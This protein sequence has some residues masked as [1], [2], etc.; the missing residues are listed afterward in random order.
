MTLHLPAACQQCGVLVVGRGVS[1]QKG[2]LGSPNGL[3]SQLRGR[4]PASPLRGAK[5]RVPVPL[6]QSW[7][8]I[9]GPPPNSSRITRTGHSSRGSTSGRAI[10][11][12]TANQHLVL[13]STAQWPS[14]EKTG[15]QSQDTGAHCVALAMSLHISEPRCPSSVNR[16]VCD[17]RPCLT[18]VLSI[19]VRWNTWNTQ[20]PRHIKCSTYGR[21]HYTN[22]FKST[23][24]KHW[25]NMSLKI[26]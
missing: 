16:R 26:T 21:Y 6:T 11:G 13:G 17:S 24:Y 19:K 12:K 7:P 9:P 18:A 23:L 10:R 3:P 8:R 15:F 2:P 4:K 1:G 5:P 14:W 22:F 25:K 20:Q